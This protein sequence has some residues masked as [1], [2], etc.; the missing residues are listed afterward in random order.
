MKSTT[1]VIFEIML[2]NTQPVTGKN[3]DSDDGERQ[4]G[5]KV[6]GREIECQMTSCDLAAVGV[7]AA[8]SRRAATCKWRKI[9]GMDR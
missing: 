4:K 3:D 7:C 5:R 1:G 8:R 6:R 9:E 2:A